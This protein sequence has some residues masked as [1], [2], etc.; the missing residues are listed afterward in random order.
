[1]RKQLK[2]KWY[3]P[4]WFVAAQKKES[5]YLRSTFT[6]PETQSPSGLIYRRDGQGNWAVYEP[7]PPRHAL[8]S[9]WDR[10]AA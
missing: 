3:S 7:F 6:E 2:S 9:A 4:R 1:M 10:K 5:A 8:Q